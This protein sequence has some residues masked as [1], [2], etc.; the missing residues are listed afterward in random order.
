MEGD[1]IMNLIIYGVIIIS[2]I[3]WVS[4]R[5]FIESSLYKNH[6]SMWIARRRV[7]RIDKMV[8]EV[9]WGLQF[10]RMELS[11]NPKVDFFRP[12]GELEIKCW[13]VKTG[14]KSK[15]FVLKLLLMGEKPEEPEEEVGRMKD[16]CTQNDGNCQTCS[17]VNY[18]RDCMNEP[19]EEEGKEVS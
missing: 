15:E 13:N 10:I 12:N 16:Y 14:N 11:S 17:L 1:L 8:E 4:Y 2:L 3:L 19:V 9:L 6:V 18:G 7:R 5:F